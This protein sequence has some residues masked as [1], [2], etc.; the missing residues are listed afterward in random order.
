[1]R[2]TGTWSKIY[3]KRVQ[4]RMKTLAHVLDVAQQEGYPNIEEN[5]NL[6]ELE[7][8]MIAAMQDLTKALYEHGPIGYHN[9]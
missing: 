2:E 1:M 7:S 6:I 4:E 9:L 8:K 3:G 5:R